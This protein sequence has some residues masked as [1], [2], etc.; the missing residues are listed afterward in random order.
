MFPPLI[1]GRPLSNSPVNNNPGSSSI[2]VT[3]AGEKSPLIFWLEVRSAG[4]GGGLAGGAL[5]V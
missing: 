3:A 1:T 5:S 2:L 4:D